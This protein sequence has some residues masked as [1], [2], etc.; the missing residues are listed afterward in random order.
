MI[1]DGVGR[2]GQGRGP[3]RR[4]TGRRRRDRPVGDG[5][6]PPAPPRGRGPA[7]PV[8]LDGVE[9]ADRQVVGHGDRCRRSR[10]PRGGVRATPGRVHEDFDPRTEQFVT[11]GR[12]DARP[13]ARC[14]SASRSRTRAGGDLAVEPGGVGAVLL[15]EGEEP[16]P[17][18]LGLVDERQQRVVVVLG[19]ARV[20]DDEVGAERGV[21]PRGADRTRCASRNRSPSP[22]RRIRRSSGRETCWSDRST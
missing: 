14:S 7:A 3:E 15:A 17:V 4:V 2:R 18:E 11:S 13:G 16:A 5:R 6:A 21:G 22:Q 19:L 20:A 10:A 8:D 12:G 9:R 1:A